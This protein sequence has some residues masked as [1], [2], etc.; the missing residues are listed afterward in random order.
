MPSNVEKLKRDRGLT[1]VY[2]HFAFGFARADSEGSWSVVQGVRDRLQTLGS[3]PKVEFL[4]AGDAL[5]RLRALQF[6][7]DSLRRG[8]TMVRLPATLVPALHNTSVDPSRIDENDIPRACRSSLTGSSVRLNTTDFLQLCELTLLL[9][10]ESR[11]VDAWRIRSLE[12]Y[13]LVY[14]WLTT[15]LLTPT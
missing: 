2:T 9:V 3:D 15:Q 8:E 6:L 13:R 12:R 14:R 5:D 11:F 7:R 4:T 1:I 10:D